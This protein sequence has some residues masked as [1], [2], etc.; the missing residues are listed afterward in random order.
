MK[1][2]YNLNM[3]L[4]LGENIIRLPFTDYQI[5][6][7]TNRGNYRKTSKLTYRSD[8]VND[9]TFNDDIL[10]NSQIRKGS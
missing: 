8:I 9:K 4:H 6:H 2:F 1:P 7:S 5:C 3:V 10:Y